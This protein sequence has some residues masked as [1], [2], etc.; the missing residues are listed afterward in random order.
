MMKES[1]VEKAKDRAIKNWRRLI[2][3]A[4][5]SFGNLSIG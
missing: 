1:A 3:A 4:N 2:Q 5:F